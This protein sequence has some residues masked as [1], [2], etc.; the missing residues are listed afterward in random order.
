MTWAAVAVYCAALAAISVVD[1]LERR[2]P[3]RIVL[4]AAVAVLAL[5]TAADPSP[6][7]ALAGLAAAGF[8][9]VP[10]LIKPE[11]LGM[12]DV[13][14]ALL[15]GFMLG[16]YVAAALAAGLVLSSLYG[17]AL[18]ATRGR[19]ATMPLAPFL[20]AGGVAALALRL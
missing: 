20:A 11:G 9:L 10:A 3:N 4:P 17:L 18:L 5:V 7:W 1:V 6:E 2:V 13:K 8:L 16:R 14:L 19:G 12:G 15:L